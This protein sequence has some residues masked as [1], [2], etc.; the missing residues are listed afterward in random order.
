MTKNTY[1]RAKFLTM[2]ASLLWVF[3]LVAL[4]L[5]AMASDQPQESEKKDTPIYYI[6]MKAPTGETVL[7]GCMIVPQEVVRYK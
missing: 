2:A 7:F 4:C 1:P 6:S 5:G 3:G